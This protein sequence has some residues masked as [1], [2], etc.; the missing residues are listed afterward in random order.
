MIVVEYQEKYSTKRVNKGQH[1]RFKQEFYK[2]IGDEFTNQG[3]S[4]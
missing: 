3:P 2:I 1:T 4:Y